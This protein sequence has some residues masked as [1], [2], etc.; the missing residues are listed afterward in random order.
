M[1]DLPAIR[2]LPRK[3]THGSNSGSTTMGGRSKS[4]K[5]IAH[6]GTRRG[7][8]GGGSG[9]GNKHNNG[10]DAESLSSTMPTFAPR[11]TLP[12]RNP[13]SKPAFVA[14]GLWGMSISYIHGSN[15]L[16][17]STPAQRK[18]TNATVY[19]SSTNTPL[20]LL[21][22]ISSLPCSSTGCSGVIAWH[23]TCA[24]LLTGQQL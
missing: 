12:A 10:S 21:S 17:I 11:R 20:L 16:K 7:G 15:E 6:H 9:S 4:S 1:E 3:S 8:P 18:C 14:A 22:L 2:V 23:L 13:F 5:R 24:C 19:H